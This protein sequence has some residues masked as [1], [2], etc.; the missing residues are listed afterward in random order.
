MYGILILYHPDLRRI[1]TDYG[2]ANFPLRKDF[3]L[4]GFLELVYTD[5]IKNVEY[6][7]VEL[8]QDFRKMEYHEH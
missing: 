4:T 8:S 6:R 3:P 5:F 7:N 2:F 1:I